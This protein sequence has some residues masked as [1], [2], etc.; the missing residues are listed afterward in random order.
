MATNVNQKSIQLP[1]GSYTWKVEKNSTISTITSSSLSFTLCAFTTPAKPM[2][3][4][5]ANTNSVLAITEFSWNISSWGVDCGRQ[6]YFDVFL[7][8][9][10]ETMKIISTQTE[11]NFS[12][13]SNIEDQTIYFW[14]VEAS[15]GEASTSSDVHTFKSCARK[16][17]NAPSVSIISPYKYFELP[18]DLTPKIL[19][20][21]FTGMNPIE[22]GSN[23]LGKTPMFSLSLISSTTSLLLDSKI[24]TS[25][26]TLSFPSTNT[27]VG[28][29]SFR[30]SV[31]NADLQIN[32]ID[33]DVVICRKP[34]IPAITY[35]NNNSSNV[36]TNL[37]ALLDIPTSYGFPC[38][39]NANARNMIGIE[40]KEIYNPNQNYSNTEDSQLQS[41]SQYFKPETK[42]ASISTKLKP[43]RN[44]S[45]RALSMNGDIDPTYSPW[46]FFTTKSIDCSNYQFSC[47]NGK[48]S[49]IA[50]GA[51]CECE[52][53]TFG[54]KC[55]ALSVS[56]LSVGGISG[57]VV[58]IIFFVGILLV[59]ILFM[60]RKLGN[61][62]VLKMPDFSKYRFTSIGA[63]DDYDKCLEP[64]EVEQRIIEDSK[65]DFSWTRKIFSSTPIT[66]AD[67]VCCSFVYL[68]EKHNLTIPF[69]LSLIRHEI[70]ETDSI[71][72]L[73]RVNSKATK[74]FK[75]FSRMVGLEFMFH[76]LAPVLRQLL[77]DE[78]KK[79]NKVVVKDNSENGV[80][81][82]KMEAS[83]ILETVE[84]NP[85]M[86]AENIEE[87]DMETNVLTLQVYCQR[88]IVA[89]KKSVIYCPDSFQLVFSFSRLNLLLLFIIKKKRFVKQ[90]KKKL[91]RNSP[92]QIFRI[93]FLLLCF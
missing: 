46:T 56:G 27:Q 85:D 77:K 87:S 84:L 91:Q 86:M 10:P 53:G 70:D 24:A 28:R 76:V 67:S 71:E 17:P 82:G 60:K 57:I 52:D 12:T 18:S 42:T 2:L 23:C 38:D 14:K 89:L 51:I 8:K 50:N 62:L 1:S 20:F 64:E 36:E 73:F 21:N 22:L 68:F 49:E 41:I 44:F 79:K 63:V 58:G 13:T 43:G 30:Y 33:E 66:E 29:I 93:L 75:V 25:N 3:I 40:I 5:P 88:F 15:N 37:R 78:T 55:S 59:G 39:P 26:Q 54:E 35:P 19:K 34:T 48:C 31:T 83:T 45:I 16:I 4:L 6:K 81:F 47:E 65:N 80:E 90:L 92:K 9:T 69:L 61:G 72:T 32:Y 74:C 11:T 7:G